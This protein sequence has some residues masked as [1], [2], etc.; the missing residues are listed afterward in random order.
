MEYVCPLCNGMSQLQT[1]CS[2]CGETLEDGGAVFDYLGPYSPYDLAPRMK[3]G[4]HQC[5]HLL[6]CTNCG[7]D[8]YAIIQN[9]V[10]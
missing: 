10:I 3:Q 4:E 1:T 7:N 6:V 5:T 2:I 9:D 8:S